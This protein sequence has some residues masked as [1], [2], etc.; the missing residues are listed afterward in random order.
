MDPLCLNSHHYNPSAIT[1]KGKLVCH[2]L[3][4]GV[5]AT[6]ASL[7][8]S[9]E[10]QKAILRFLTKVLDTTRARDSLANP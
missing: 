10:T 7:P 3:R 4:V 6:Q 5:R 2:L 9:L 1:C 8:K